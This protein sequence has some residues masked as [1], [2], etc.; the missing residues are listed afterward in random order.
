MKLPM[1]EKNSYILMILLG[2]V[3]GIVLYLGYENRSGIADWFSS[4][5]KTDQ[6]EETE[7]DYPYFVPGNRDQYIGAD[8]EWYF[9][10]FQPEIVRYETDGDLNYAVV[11]YVP[12]VNLQDTNTIDE[13]YEVKIL[14]SSE[15][16]LDQP[17]T[18]EQ[19]ATSSEDLPRMLSEYIRYWSS[20]DYDEL[21]DEATN[22][23]ITFEQFKEEFPVGSR[24]SMRVLAAYPEDSV[25]TDEY[26]LSSDF[27]ESVWVCKYVE[28]LPDMFEEL[29]AFYE[30]SEVSDDFSLILY[31]VADGLGTR[32]DVL[33]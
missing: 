8:S 4:L 14:V 28:L 13:E 23:L 21:D 3:L 18:D 24:V 2:L 5:T 15:A 1:S 16:H 33:K 6:Q 31:S 25:R 11:K 19:P 22:E 32:E 17:D 9:M 12:D 30:G 26:C 29:D 7:E 27:L 20:F 10:L